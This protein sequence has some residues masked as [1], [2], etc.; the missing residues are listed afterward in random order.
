MEENSLVEH[1]V[2]VTGERI[3]FLEVCF[4]DGACAAMHLVIDEILVGGCGELVLHVLHAEEVVFLRLGI[5]HIL[6]E[7]FDL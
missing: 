5:G 1:G 7:R 3:L 6:N 4:V 2:H